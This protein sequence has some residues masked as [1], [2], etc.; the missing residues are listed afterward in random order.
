MIKGLRIFSF[1]LMSINFV[2]PLA[3]EGIYIKAPLSK[4]YLLCLEFHPD[5]FRNNN[6]SL[7]FGALAQVCDQAGKVAN[8]QTSGEKQQGVLGL[9]STAFNLASQLSQEKPEKKSVSK[10]IVSLAEMIYEESVKS[11]IDGVFDFANAWDDVFVL[12]S[13]EEREQKII[14]ICSNDLLVDDFLYNMQRALQRIFI[15]K[16][17]NIKEVILKEL[18]DLISQFAQTSEAFPSVQELDCLGVLPKETR[19][20]DEN[21]SGARDLISISIEKIKL[22]EPIDSSAILLTENEIYAKSFM[23]AVAAYKGSIL[24]SEALCDLLSSDESFIADIMKYEPLF[25]EELLAREPGRERA[26]FAQ[27][28]FR[29][30]GVAMEMIDEVLAGLVLYG[31]SKMNKQI[32]DLFGKAY[33]YLSS[34]MHAESIEEDEKIFV[35]SVAAEN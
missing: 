23:G 35:D 30:P 17:V 1:L 34:D 10:A 18:N 29:Y 26:V 12:Q 25:I 28:A 4:E 7:V 14:E 8:A 21:D 33:Y 11:N 6:G 20:F 3:A 16:M 31:C 27:K 2:I 32:H 24:L 13:A 15:K 5:F 9:F 22:E 19:A